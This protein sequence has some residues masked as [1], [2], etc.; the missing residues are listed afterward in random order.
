MQ[1]PLP[2]INA[3]LCLH[4]RLCLRLRWCWCLPM[5]VLPQ[6]LV[7]TGSMELCMEACSIDHEALLRLP[8]YDRPMTKH[9][10]CSNYLPRYSRLASAI[11]AAATRMSTTIAITAVYL[12]HCRWLL[13]PHECPR[14]RPARVGPIA[15]AADGQDGDQ[16]PL[17]LNM[18]I[19]SMGASAS[20][21]Y[22]G[23]T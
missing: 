7:P 18:Y 17:G 3:C 10:S 14:L 16:D 21:R 23:I 13:G 11:C 19:R 20:C 1:H 9:S 12:M 2:T 5:P 4:L 6:S 15:H 8:T 22:A